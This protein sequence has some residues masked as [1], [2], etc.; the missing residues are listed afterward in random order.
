VKILEKKT[1]R[2]PYSFDTN[3]LRTEIKK[4]AVKASGATFLSQAAAFLIQMTGTIVL[5]RLLTP[6][7][8][9]LITMVTT[10]SLLLQ[11]VGINGFTEAIIQRENISQSA[12]NT[13]FWLNAG[14]SLS[15]TLLLIA[16]APIVAQFYGEPRLTLITV[17]ISLSIISTG[18]ST[19]HLA[20]LKRNMQF[21]I[22]SF[23][24]VVSTFISVGVAIL[25][26]WAGLQY[27]A[28]VASAIVSQL[29][30]AIGAW[31]FCK[32]RPGRPSQ[33]TNVTQMVKFAL[34][35]YGRFLLNYSSR[36]LD[37]LLVGKYL[38]IQPLG[39]YK[40]AYD[41][42]ALSAGQVTDPLANVAL[43]ALSRFSMD[44][45]KFRRNYLNVIAKITFVSIALSLFLTIT[46]KDIILLVL[47]PQWNKAAEIF[48]FFGPGIGL[49]IISA[50]QGWLHLSLGRA[51]RWFRWGILEFIVTA[52]FFV[53][54]LRFGPSGVAI[55]WTASFC[56]LTGP[57]LWYAGR[58]V[59]LKISALFS[60]IWRYFAAGFSAGLLSRFILYS[61]PVTAGIF[62]GLNLLLR[63]IVSFTICTSLYM[64]LTIVFYRSLKPVTQSISLAREMLPEFLTKKGLI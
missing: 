5:A 6:A 35:T 46:A 53:V 31:I 63:I 50:T 28:L 8:F 61:L 16:L 3:Q 12:I 51:D 11:N 20:L 18:F 57:G 7:D 34:H 36:N 39:Y 60:N 17:A 26:A 41:L 25:L 37:K 47:G 58:P 19:I 54:G 23:I 15:I 56:V 48:M 13:L 38:G 45:D 4:R 1:L 2:K 21:Y 64:L 43:A 40:K 59:Q 9:G 10:F 49:M 33:W 42:F 62:S 52:T 29:I 32:W 30:M 55:A 27:W 44:H 14:I 22:T 24:S